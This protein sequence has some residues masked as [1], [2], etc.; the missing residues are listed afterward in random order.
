MTNPDCACAHPILCAPLLNELDGLSL[1][2][3]HTA[4][5]A[6]GYADWNDTTQ[7]RVFVIEGVE[8]WLWVVPLGNYHQHRHLMSEN[9]DVDHRD[10]QVVLQ[11]VSFEIN[12]V[13]FEDR[14]ETPIFPTETAIRTV[15]RNTYP[16]F[17]DA[18]HTMQILDPG[19]TA[20][21][22]REA[23]SGMA[24]VSLA[25][26]LP[27]NASPETFHAHRRRVLEKHFYEAANT[28]MTHKLDLPPCPH[29]EGHCVED[30]RFFDPDPVE[31]LIADADD[32][33]RRIA[34][35]LE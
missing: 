12:G 5:R 18:L 31:S 27:E 13:Q 26:S 9:W 34:E 24:P 15:L 30:D 2:A 21:Q 29:C 7:P 3:L 23:W 1:D 14:V 17:L 20:E 25:K 32:L 35:A 4:M 19:V 22:I 28:D 33:D 11:N 8:H 16:L 10:T 6:M